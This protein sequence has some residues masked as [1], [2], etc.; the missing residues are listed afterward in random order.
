MKR[1]AGVLCLMMLT[2]APIAAFAQEPPVGHRVVIRKYDRLET[3]P[4]VYGGIVVTVDSD[5]RIPI[6]PNQ[7][8]GK[9][10]LVIVAA[11]QTDPAIAAMMGGG[12]YMLRYEDGRV[13]E[14]NGS[15][16]TNLMVQMFRL[17]ATLKPTRIVFQ[18]GLGKPIAGATVE[19]AL[20]N[21]SNPSG[22]A[23]VI[24]SF[25]TDETGAV[26]LP[27]PRNE[28]GSCVYTLNHERYGT[29]LFTGVYSGGSIRLALLPADS[30]VRD[31]AL[32]GRVVTADGKPA[33]G[34]P[35]TIE[36]VRTPGDGLIQQNLYTVLT[37]PDGRFRAYLPDKNLNSEIGDII[38]P[39]S[40][41]YF[42][43][44]VPDD[45]HQ[46]KM[47]FVK[48]CGA[49]VEIK[50]EHGDKLR[51]FVF[52]DKSGPITIPE[53]LERIYV[54]FR[55]KDSDAVETY[56][57]AELLKEAWYLPGTY[58]AVM[59]DHQGTTI[60][61]GPVKIEAGS[62]DVVVFRP[63]SNRI[64]EG[65]I[66]DIQTSGPLA[67][68]V[69][70]AMEGHVY[71]K[72]KLISPVQWEA[73]RSLPH[74]FKQNDPALDP[75]K[76]FYSFS[77]AVKS[78]S[79][80]RFRLETKDGTNVYGLV[81]A[82]EHYV[83]VMRRVVELVPDAGGKI[84]LG[85]ICLFPSAKVSFNVASP[86]SSLLRLLASWRIDKAALPDRYKNYFFPQL[87]GSAPNFEYPYWLEATSDVTSNTVE[88][89]SGVNLD[90]GISQQGGY[91]KPILIKNI[92]LAQGEHKDYG[93]IG[94]FEKMVTAL[95]PVQVI[96]PQGEPI[97][98]APVHMGVLTGEMNK[99]YYGPHNADEQ[100]TAYF[101]VDP[102]T[103]G[104]FA[105]LIYQGR[106]L[107][108]LASVPFN[109]AE[110]A[111]SLPVHEI[112]LTAEQVAILRE[113]MYPSVRKYEP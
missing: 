78:G 98:G 47:S 112:K 41:Y 40:K 77:Q 58:E 61:F 113:S 88:V 45:P 80:G 17:D 22:R 96:G 10:S 108:P 27:T 106:N 31:R 110:E 55:V 7:L 16:A 57:G 94:D 62:P 3:D 81:A 86:D 46:P 79:D 105:I 103:Q 12:F 73:I 44:R 23:P 60:K 56:L 36:Y 19:P 37:G 43:A 66:I 1:I 69:V 97:E 52:E 101:F 102:G 87:I 84:T 42:S 68:V 21:Y 76:Q 85:D 20:R 75:L 38:P 30:T 6:E 63:Q 18:D 48:P 51:R 82:D 28:Y 34:A 83:C 25:K 8:K 14:K 99:E 29:A 39:G 11:D 13:F 54:Q 49:E 2:L 35:I 67:E 74:D 93:K 5:Q 72:S 59:N 53:W 95:I 33:A 107:K 64:Y 70:F 104:E 71:G 4:V 111:T 65:R 90:V 15:A 89:P 100:G 91:W 92:R 50:L 9:G 24:G 26:E 32:N 109:C